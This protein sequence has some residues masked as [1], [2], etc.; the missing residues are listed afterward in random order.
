MRDVEYGQ[1]FSRLYLES[2]KERREK[3]EAIIEEIVDKDITSQRLDINRC[4]AT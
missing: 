2:Q 3:I 4:S 1:S